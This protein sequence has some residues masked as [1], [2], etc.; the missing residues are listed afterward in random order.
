MTRFAFLI[1]I[2]G[3]AEEPADHPF[4]DTGILEESA[5][6][7]AA[8]APYRDRL[9]FYDGGLRRRGDSFAAVDDCNTCTCEGYNL[10]SCTE[11]ACL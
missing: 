3:C 9:C 5:R 7:P 4:S 8:L 2:A 10:V 6:L 11:M 1:L